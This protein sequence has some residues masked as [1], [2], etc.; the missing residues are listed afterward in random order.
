MTL[1]TRED[2]DQALAAIAAH[3]R[4]IDLIEAGLNEAI[5]RLKAQA[6]EAAREHIAARYNLEA[7]ME[8][9]A[10]AGRREFFAEGKTMSLPHGEVGFRASTSLRLAHRGVSWEKV[11]EK[12]TETGRMDAVRVTREVNKDVLKTWPPS[13]L[14]AY[15]VKLKAS[16]KF[17]VRPAVEKL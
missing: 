9:A 13:A 1:K 11:L 2:F 12:L 8:A 17:F 16:E 15:E 3:Q 14:A 7:Q 4:E 10:E 5:D 6:N